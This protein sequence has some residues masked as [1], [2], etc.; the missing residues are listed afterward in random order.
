MMVTSKVMVAK[1]LAATVPRST[2][3][4]GVPPL[5]L[6]IEPSVVVTEPGTRVVT[7]SG[8]SLKTTPVAAPLPLLVM[9]T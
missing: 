2:P 3:T 4:G 1:A 9:V 6:R 8:I 7:L 5:P